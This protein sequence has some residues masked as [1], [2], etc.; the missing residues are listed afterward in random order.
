MGCHDRYED[1]RSTTLS[2]KSLD[3]NMM[4]SRSLRA[5]EHHPFQVEVL[6]M[7][8][9][10]LTDDEM[11]AV[12]N[13]CRLLHVADRDAFFQAIADALRQRGELGPRPVRPA[14]AQLQRPLS[15]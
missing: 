11:T 4:T 6:S 13:A 15:R 5:D 7:S 3:H 9:L 12:Y 8:L 1:S 14:V 2:Q 10:K